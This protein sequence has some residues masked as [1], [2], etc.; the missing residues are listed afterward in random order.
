M[1]VCET[2]AAQRSLK[3]SPSGEWHRALS[4]AEKA[5]GKG[6]GVRP[7][8]GWLPLRPRWFPWWLSVV[9]T[10]PT[11]RLVKPGNYGILNAVSG[12]QAGC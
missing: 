12:P 8:G 4:T 11:D 7:G 3:D 9:S 2:E 1:S 6:A 5:Q 10:K